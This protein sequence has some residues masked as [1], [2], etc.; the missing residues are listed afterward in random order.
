MSS[1]PEKRE[2]SGS[3]IDGH[4]P[5]SRTGDRA[6]GNYLTPDQRETNRKD[7]IK[8]LEVD[9]LRSRPV[10]QFHDEV[11]EAEAWL[12]D[13]I[14]KRDGNHAH[15]RRVVV[16]HWTL[17]GIWRDEFQFSGPSQWKHDDP[18]SV[19]PKCET[20]GD[21]NA[22]LLTREERQSAET[23]QLKG[24]EASRPCHRFQ[25]QI[26]LEINSLIQA[27]ATPLD[28]NISPKDPSEAP[29][30]GLRKWIQALDPEIMKKRSQLLPNITTK[31]YWRVKRN[32]QN[33]GIWDDTWP[34][35]PVSSWNWKHERPL[36]DL[37]R[38][39]GLE[40][41]SKPESPKGADSSGS[42]RA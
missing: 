22:S 5:A 33:R 9:R 15:A 41:P 1:S 14:G 12:D 34:M 36:E 35:V 19:E 39:A 16:R 23:Q 24:Y 31:A 27:M 30:E 29:E 42:T 3:E 25:F 18:D 10:E 6:F 20:E 7:A 17:H 32:W 38:E 2:V 11:K 26:L 21:D 8:K 37:I 4:D 40:E 13:T 28:F